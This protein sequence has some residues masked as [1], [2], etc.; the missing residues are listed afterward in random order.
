MITIAG[1]RAG[2][3]REWALGREK[4]GRP[5]RVSEL[6]DVM[7]FT[8]FQQK[9]EM[10]SVIHV[11][12]TPAGELLE[13]RFEMLN[14]RDAPTRMSGRVVGDKLILTNEVGGQ[15]QRSEKAWKKEYLGPNSEGRLLR[16]KPL[17][18]GESRTFSLFDILQGKVITVKQSAAEKFADEPVF[19]KSKKSL[20][21]VRTELNPQ[22]IVDSYLDEKAVVWKEVTSMLGGIAKHRVTKA[23]ALKSV[24][25]AEL[26]LA[27]AM[28]VKVEPIRNA[29]TSKNVVYLVQVPGED[30]A[31]L[32]PAG[33]TQAINFLAKDSA[34]LTVTSILPPA[35]ATS[36]PDV[37]SKY[38]QP[39]RYL[40]TEDPR[41]KELAETAAGNETDPW[42]TA[43]ALEKWVA[44]N[45]KSKNFSTVF[46]SAS[47]VAETLSGDCT[48]H[49]V[50]LAALCRV[51]EI[52]A[53]IAVGLVYVDRYQA[54]VGHA[55]TE[56]YVHGT[57]VPL[58]ATLG[59]G[60]VAAD[61]IKFSDSALD[62]DGAAFLEFLPLITALGKMQ[63]RVV[64][65]E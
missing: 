55:W 12:E 57:W 16:E 38:R 46:A 52:P 9:L 35:S 45:L 59:Q 54:F 62:G 27:A 24:K 26:D 32:L 30:V 53:R 41:L 36:A 14:L 21:R 28:L 20:L 10:R 39:N 34:E 48:E 19:D 13:F 50:L 6:E 17:K 11:Q 58:D 56:V 33:S 49:A 65:V 51:K 18:P 29:A 37:A 8:R 15:T 7:S 43:V 60:R 63:I 2:Y 4:D 1:Q 22:L 31:Q 47:E 42:K 44:T 25:G 23:E 5:V 3:S 64:S 40:Q 61:H